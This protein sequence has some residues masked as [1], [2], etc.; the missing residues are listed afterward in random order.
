[1]NNNLIYS[2]L[3]NISHEV[4]EALGNYLGTFY[5]PMYFKTVINVVKHSVCS[6]MFVRSVQRLALV[7]TAQK[8]GHP[9]IFFF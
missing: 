4:A 5:V 1:M 8:D 2:F 6:N 7:H 9:F 3:D